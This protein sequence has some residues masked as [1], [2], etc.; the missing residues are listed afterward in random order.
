VLEATLTLGEGVDPAAV[1]AAV[2]TELCGHWEHEGGCRWPHNNEIAAE[3][4]SGRA[5]FRT[6][7]LAPEHEQAEA[8][9]RIEKALREGP[10]WSVE[11]TGERDLS[12]NEA[13]LAIRMAR[14]PP[15]IG[16]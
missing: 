2:T 10:G 13:E 14:A 8:R 15:P 6:L 1:G 3:G 5:S 4:A 7:F 11:S 12:G 16:G 9:T